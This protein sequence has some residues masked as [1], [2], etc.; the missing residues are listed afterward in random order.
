[1][2][3]VTDTPIGASVFKNIEGLEYFDFEEDFIEKNMRCIPMI[4]RLKMD[5]A[6]I[7]L[8]LAE[9][10]KFSVNDRIELAQ[11]DCGR[12]PEIESYYNYT[13]NLI[14]Q[15]TGSQATFMAIDEQPL[16]AQ[17]EVIPAVLLQHLF[18]SGCNMTLEQ[19][20]ALTQ[21]QRFALLKLCR[22]G[23][24]NKNFP[25]ALKEFGLI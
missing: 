12:K 19:W 11:R 16:W 15:Y 10:A 20:S 7:K 24:E 25:K 2:E 13:V 23:H 9:W 14:R 3:A 5:K 1:M 4:V 22:P 21:L 17:Q 8:K 18:E 6:G